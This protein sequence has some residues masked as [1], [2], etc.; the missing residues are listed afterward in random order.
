MR[1]PGTYERY[2]KTR[3][4]MEYDHVAYAIR[5]R[6]SQFMSGA[7]AYRIR[8]MVIFHYHNQ[9]IRT[10]L[11]IDFGEEKKNNERLFSR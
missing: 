2:S 7:Y 8:Y 11:E 10:E 6:A 3:T 5:V 9:S 1:Y 4:S